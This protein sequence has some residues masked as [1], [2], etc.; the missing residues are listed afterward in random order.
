MTWLP[1]ILVPGFLGLI[2]ISGAW[3]A[4]TPARQPSGPPEAKTSY[5]L[6]VFP[7]LTP[8]RLE[9]IYAPI[10]ADFRRALGH[11]VHFRTASQFGL[12][13]ERLKAEHYDIALIQ[14][15]WYVPA[16]DRFGYL[17]LARIVEPLSSVIVVLDESL[18]K[19]IEDLRGKT[20]AAPPV[21]APV[22]RMAIKALRERDVVPGRDLALKHVKSIDSCFQQVV[23]GTASACI[24]GPL[25][26]PMIE[27]KLKVKLR[28]LMKTPGIPNLTFVVHSRVAAE[29][30]ERLRQ[31]ILSWRT[32]DSGRRLLQG[33]G[34]RG[35]VQASDAEYDIVR[36]LLKEAQQP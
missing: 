28:I 10:S 21:F 5:R 7:Y 22:S 1:K 6:G 27:K 25:A 9:P 4:D 31:A 19:S 26:P 2:G 24:S 30:R 3:A 20:V 29:D 11:P 32:N 12:F 36:T 8:L 13:F 15:L 14:P 34:T 23:I 18:L 35:F 17:P 33:I 16:V